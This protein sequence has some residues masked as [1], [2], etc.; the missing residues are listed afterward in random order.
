[1]FTVTKS[2]EQGATKILFRW[3]QVADKL[4]EDLFVRVN[5]QTV[6]VSN[7]GGRTIT[8]SYDA[9]FLGDANRLLQVMRE[10]FPEL[11]LTRQECI[12]TSWINSTVY[13]GGYTIK[14]S[15]EVL[16]QR[17]NILKHY[18]KAKS[19]FVRQPIPETALK[20]LWEIMLEEDKPAIVLTPY[21]RNMGKISESQTPFPHRKGTL[22][23]IQYLANWR[24]AKENVRKHTDWTR[25]V[26]RYMKPCASM[27]PRQAYVNYRDLDLG[28]NKETNTSFP[29]VSGWGTKYFK[30]NFYRLVRVK[31][32]VDPDNFFRHEQ[33]IPTLPH[34]MR[35]RN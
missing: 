34:H 14:I 3:Q 32:K 30:D 5:I 19:D 21:G 7:K 6:N 29:G 10:S 13:L 4:D 1:M 26:Y 16:L 11:G 25:M 27:F 9:L 12:E 22:F 35:K 2:L 31:T 24:D 18:F 15:P 33:S 20:G 23:M 17:R 8:T 28:M